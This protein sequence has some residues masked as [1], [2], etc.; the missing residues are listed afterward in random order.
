VE[1]LKTLDPVRND[2]DSSFDSTSLANLKMTRVQTREFLLSSY[3]RCGIPK[4][5]EFLRSITR[6]A[7]RGLG[8]DG[9]AAFAHT[10]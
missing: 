6:H 3:K 4:L 1:E 8:S 2:A 5:I 9:V 10:S 7:R